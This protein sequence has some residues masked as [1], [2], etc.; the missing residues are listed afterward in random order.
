MT[1]VWL[2]ERSLGGFRPDALGIFSDPRFA[3]EVCQDDA[4][5]Y[6]GAERTEPLDWV[7]D[8]GFRSASHYQ[9]PGTT[10]YQITRFTVDKREEP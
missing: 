3:M 2:A 10:F 5:A 7:G 6:F 1:D 9:P 4:N 8:D